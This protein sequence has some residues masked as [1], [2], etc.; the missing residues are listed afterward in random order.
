MGLGFP[1]QDDD[2]VVVTD[3][4]AR[5][6]TSH[7]KPEWTMTHMRSLIRA[8]VASMSA[9]TRREQ[10]PITYESEQKALPGP[11]VHT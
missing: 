2:I 11:A 10:L 9:L 4:R 5:R 3:L 1:F 6:L 8:R 7:W